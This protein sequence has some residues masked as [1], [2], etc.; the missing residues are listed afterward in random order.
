MEDVLINCIPIV[1]V[2]MNNITL[3]NSDPIQSL[4]KG[5][6]FLNLYFE[7][8]DQINC[9][10]F[11]LRNFGVERFNPEELLNQINRIVN[12]YATDYYAFKTISSLKK[13]STKGSVNSIERESWRESD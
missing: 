5:K 13:V 4:S 8:A 7:D 6:Q 10:K 1:N 12:K 3:R 11:S 2:E 9:D